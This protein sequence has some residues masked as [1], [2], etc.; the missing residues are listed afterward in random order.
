M[1]VYQQKYFQK[2]NSNRIN[3]NFMIQRKGFIVWFS[4]RVAQKYK[5]IRN[6]LTMNGRF[7]GCSRELLLLEPKNCDDKK[8][9]L[10]TEQILGEGHWLHH[11]AAQKIY[12]LLFG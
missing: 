1:Y 10:S 9:L 12:I 6:L 8:M 5:H 4:E 2:V 7:M 11:F 3:G